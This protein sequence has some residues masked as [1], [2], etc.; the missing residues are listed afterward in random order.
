MNL[1]GRSRKRDLFETTLRA[2]RIVAILL[3]FLENT[4]P[5]SKH[6]PIIIPKSLLIAFGNV[7]HSNWTHGQQL[8]HAVQ[9]L[10][11]AAGVA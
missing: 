6:D 10:I 5:N 8:N 7:A 9:P 11:K 2:Y 1:D 3:W 4:E